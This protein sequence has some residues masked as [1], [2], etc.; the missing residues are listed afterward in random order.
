M[1]LADLIEERAEILD[2]LYYA[3]GEERKDLIDSLFVVND[4]IREF[5]RALGVDVP[6]ITSR[7]VGVQEMMHRRGR[8]GKE[9]QEDSRSQ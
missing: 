1:S 9:V 4:G 7:S 6:T 5:Q 8:R 2:A 3:V